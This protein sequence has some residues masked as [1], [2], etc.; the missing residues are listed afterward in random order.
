MPAKEGLAFPLFPFGRC[1][2]L[3][4]PGAAIAPDTL[5]SVDLY[6]CPHSHGL[7]TGLSYRALA[8]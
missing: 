7:L 5:L 6:V 8:P 2:V 3:C 1:S 4:V